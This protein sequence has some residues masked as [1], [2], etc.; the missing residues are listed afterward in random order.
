MRG[1]DDV[2]SEARSMNEQIRF[3]CGGQ[4][5]T[6]RRSEGCSGGRDENGSDRPRPRLRKMGVI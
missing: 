1:T 5:S 2:K 4:S 3:G 6:Q